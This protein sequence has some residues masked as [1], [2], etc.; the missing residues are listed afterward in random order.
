M[1]R[2]SGE[3]APDLIASA[4][5]T[6]A[7]VLRAKTEA[8]MGAIAIALA[9]VTGAWI[10]SPAKSSPRSALRSFDGRARSLAS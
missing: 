7:C 3:D 6:N 9:V 4:P 5:V 8:A 2:V 10:I 1:A